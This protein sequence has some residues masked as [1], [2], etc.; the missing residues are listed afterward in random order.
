MRQQI[1][2]HQFAGRNLAAFDLLR[3]AEEIA[4]KQLESK[5]LAIVEHFVG[6]DFLGQQDHIEWLK[7]FNMA[8]YLGF[9]ESQHIDLHDVGNMQRGIPLVVIDEIV[10]RYCVA[11]LFQGLQV[12]I[13]F[14]IDF[15]VLE[16]F[17]DE[18]FLV[19][20]RWIED[21]IAGEIDVCRMPLHDITD[22]HFVEGIEEDLRRGRVTIEDV[23]LIGIVR[24]KQQLV[25]SY[26]DVL[27]EDWLSGQEYVLIS[28]CD[29]RGF[30]LGGIVSEQAFFAM[31][32]KYIC[33]KSGHR[34]ARVI[35]P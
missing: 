28:H 30:R 22:V 14:L 16:H 1:E 10:Q 34:P 31:S 2:D 15:D 25:G 17:N 18:A 12:A 5:R 27:I 24:S 7:Q 9:V 26:L 29:S 21:Q 13:Q 19:E 11:G 20:G 32:L 4:L 8:L 35:R 23:C 3:L 6:F 33:R